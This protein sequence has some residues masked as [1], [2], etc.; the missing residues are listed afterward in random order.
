MLLFG[1]AKKNLFFYEPGL[2]IAIITIT[3]RVAIVGSE[4]AARSEAGQATSIGVCKQFKELRGRFEYPKN[5]PPILPFR[6]KA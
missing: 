2:T 6:G 4:K 5:S 1:A 3:I